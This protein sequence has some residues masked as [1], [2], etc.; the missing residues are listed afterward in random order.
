[1]R[2]TP[3]AGLDQERLLSTLSTRRQ[4]VAMEYEDYATLLDSL[5]VE[6]YRS[7]VGWQ[8][9]LGS[10]SWTNVV[11]VGDKILMPL[12]PDS[13]RCVTTSVMS[14]GGQMRISLDVSD[15][16]EE[17][18]E[19]RDLNQQNQRLYQRLGYEVVTVPEYLHYMMGGIHCFVNVLE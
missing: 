17:K 2:F 14:D 9:V 18:F 4:T 3:F 10:M 13:L 7:A 16:G 5:D 15:I 8:Q 11:Q 1:M 6:V 19:L 12:Y